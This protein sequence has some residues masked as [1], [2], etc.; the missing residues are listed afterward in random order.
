MTD[1]L[2]ML[3][4]DGE[5]LKGVVQNDACLPFFNEI[6]SDSDYVDGS[7]TETHS[8]LCSS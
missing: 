8:L 1:D 7:A 4:R 6:Q 3:S 5:D 2:T